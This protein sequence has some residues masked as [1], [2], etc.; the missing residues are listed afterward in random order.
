MDDNEALMKEIN[1]RIEKRKA[2]TKESLV[3]N[4]WNSHC[5]ACGE[6]CDPNA[7]KHEVTYGWGGE[8]PG[9]MVEWKYV[10]SDYCL[11]KNVA[12]ATKKMRPDLIYW[13]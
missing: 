10:T 2:L 1:E 6:G 9:C 7:K 5:G 4:L 8:K 11:D 3:I 12:E 13:D